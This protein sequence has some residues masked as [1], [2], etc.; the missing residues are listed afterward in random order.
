MQVACPSIPRPLDP[1][2]G[3]WEADSGTQGVTLTFSLVATCSD[4]LTPTALEAVQHPHH[5]PR[6]QTPDKN[7]PGDQA[8]AN[9][10]VTLPGASTACLAP[11]GTQRTLATRR[12][13]RLAG[14]TRSRCPSANAVASCS[15]G[16]RPRPSWIEGRCRAGGTWWDPDWCEGTLPQ[17]QAPC[18]VHARVPGELVTLT[19]PSGVDGAGLRG[20][21]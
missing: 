15:S 21:D 11:L 14:G 13:P 19:G 17:T 1:T 9:L 10:A 8:G 16:P 5:H 12:P 18:Q 3:N 4:K 7:Q 20:Q 6:L 2:G